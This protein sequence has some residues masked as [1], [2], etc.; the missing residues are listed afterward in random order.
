LSIL[1]IVTLGSVPEEAAA[2]KQTLVAAR[3]ETAPSSL[4]DPAWDQSKGLEIRLSGKERFAGREAIVTAKALHTQREVCFWF[5]WADTTLSVTKEAWRFDGQ[6]WS[7]LKGNE[8]RL[9]LLFEIDRIKDFATRGCAVTCHV[10]EAAASAK[11]GRFGTLTATEKGDLWHWKAA[12]SD[13]AGFADDTWLTQVTDKAGGRKSDA[14]RGGDRKNADPTNSKPM[15]MLAPGRAFAKNGIL[16]AAD[17]V[18][19]RD[20]SIFK[21]SDVITYRM[22]VA[23]DGSVADIKAQSRWVDGRWTLMLTRSLDTGHDDDVA[24]NPVRRYS[25]A[26]ALFDDSGDEDSYDS[27]ALTLEFRP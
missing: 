25:F 8:D 2:V 15:Y 24:F 10:P 9:A 21:S 22:P 1:S 4:E 23:P 14:G 19:I 13:P 7:H 17:A 16:L 5:G 3:V 27:E 6:N 11:G 26:M 12:R 20:Y 18:E